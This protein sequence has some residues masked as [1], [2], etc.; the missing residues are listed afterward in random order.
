MPRHLPR[1]PSDHKFSSLNCRTN[2][3]E[4]PTFG[5]QTRAQT[6]GLLRQAD[7]SLPF[8]FQ[9]RRD[10]GSRAGRAHERVQ[11][12]RRVGGRNRRHTSRAGDG[13][14]IARAGSETT[15]TTTAATTRTRTLT[16]TN[17]TTVTTRTT[18]A[19]AR[20]V[21]DI[22]VAAAAAADDAAGKG[23]DCRAV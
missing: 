1:R 14:R 23:G 21:K 16:A 18:V 9:V 4:N 19:R 10:A 2:L 12:V 15:T 13:D 7:A 8:L 5:R 17:M 6:D 22:T 3:R 11:K 20:W